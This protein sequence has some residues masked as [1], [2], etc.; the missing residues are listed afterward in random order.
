MTRIDA[1]VR[2]HSPEYAKDRLV[3]FSIEDWTVSEVRSLSPQ[4]IDTENLSRR[5]VF[6]DFVPKNIVPESLSRSKSFKL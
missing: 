3:P 1:I 4:R 6:R 2:P 5:R